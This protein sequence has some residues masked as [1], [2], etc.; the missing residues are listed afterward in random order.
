MSDSILSQAEIDELCEPLKQ[1]AAQIRHLRR[2]GMVV[3]RKRNGRPAVARAEYERVFVKKAEGQ[4]H[5]A[6]P[7]NQPDTAALML[8]LSK[9]RGNGAQAQGR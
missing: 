1:P 8:A 7:S 3:E 4:Q 5:E 9:G 2:M 6:P